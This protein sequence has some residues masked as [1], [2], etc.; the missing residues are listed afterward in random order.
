[1]RFPREKNIKTKEIIIKSL[2]NI[3]ID[4]LNSNVFEDV[5]KETLKCF[6]K[7]FKSDSKIKNFKLMKKKPSV[8][9]TIQC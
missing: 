6:Y 4:T 9:I 3:A 5:N 8:E 2:F 7:N 1:M